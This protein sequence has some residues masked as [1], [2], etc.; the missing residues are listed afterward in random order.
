MIPPKFQKNQTVYLL[1][2]EGAIKCKIKDVYNI[3]RIWFYKVD[4][5]DF[6]CKYKLDY[7]NEKY[8]SKTCVCESNNEPVAMEE[9]EK[10]LFESEKVMNRL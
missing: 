5:Q 2:G 6:Y 7:V 4:L 8:L 9:F 10:V 3:C 1:V